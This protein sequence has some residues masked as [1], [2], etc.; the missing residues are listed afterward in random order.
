MTGALIRL[1][2][3]VSHTCGYYDDRQATNLVIDP[4]ISDM[5]GVYDHAVRQG[6]RRSGELV[7]RPNCANCRMCTPTRLPVA[8]F[9]PNRSQRRILANNLDVESFLVTPPIKQE[10][11]DLFKRYVGARHKGGGMEHE[12]LTEVNQ[13]VASRWSETHLFEL[14][15]GERLLA[16]A[17]TDIVADGL[18]AVYTFFDPDLKDRSLGTLA[19]LQQLELARRLKLKYLYLGYW[20]RGHPKMDYKTKFAGL[21]ILHSGEWRSFAALPEPAIATPVGTGA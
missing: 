8:D 12:S 16:V 21:Q 11:Y 20:L 2:E 4:K 17:V 19:I 3:T 7:Y 18:S 10:H 15:Q 9:R 6:F 13:F 1:Y 14:W 5:A